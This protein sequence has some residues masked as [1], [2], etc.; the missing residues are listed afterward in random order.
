MAD[1]SGATS[2]NG[3]YLINQRLIDSELVKYPEE[4]EQVLKELFPS[5]DPLDDPDFNIV[6]YINTLFPTEQSLASI[7]EVVGKI[8]HK[9]QALDEEIRSVIRHVEFFLNR[10]Q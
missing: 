5:E 1:N 4:V 9:T 2:S 3:D 6:N 7:D 10:F 8:C